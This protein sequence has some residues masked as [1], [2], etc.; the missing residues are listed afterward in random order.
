MTDILQVSQLG[1]RTDD[2]VILQDINLQLGKGQFTLL[3]GPS[4][5]G[6]STLLKLIASLISPTSGS[7]LFEG[8]DIQTI[9]PERYRQQVCWCAQTPALFGDTV[10]DNLA[11][12]WQLRQK[13]PDS[14]RLTAD[15]ARL[16]L[17]PE[18]L[19]KPISELSG[20]EKQRVSLIRN[21]QFLPKVLL[22]DEITSAL[23]QSNKQ[24][25]NDLIHGYV[26]QESLAVLWVTHD[27]SE[28][29]NADDV[30]TL[31]GR[32]EAEHERA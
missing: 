7:I 32:G 12:P 1:Y 13:M 10:Y 6:K 30:I 21:L 31:P 5:C 29:D 11:F 27:R 18:T 24:R 15:L 8:R 3:T 4:G 22:L 28:I 14:G 2:A 25:V 17:P 19:Q 9:V 26:K 16:D 20:G 23:D